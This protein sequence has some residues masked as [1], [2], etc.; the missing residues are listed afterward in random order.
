MAPADKTDERSIV[1]FVLEMRN[2]LERY[3]EEAKENLQQAQA[4]QKKWYDQQARFRKLQPGQKVLLLLLTSTSKLLAKWQGPYTVIRKM[5]PVTYEILHPDKRKSHQTYHVN[6]LKEWKET[7]NETPERSLMVRKVDEPAPDVRPQ[8]HPAKVNLSHLNDPLRAE[9]QDL[10]DRFPLLFRQRSGRTELVQHSIHL[11]D[12]TPSR[13][14]PYRIPERLLKP[15]GEEIEM[16]QLHVIEPSNSEWSSP[17]VIVPKKDGSLRVCVDFRKL[18]AQSR[19][20]AYTMPRIDDL[21]EWIGQARYITTLDLRKGYWQVPLDP[22]S[23]PYTA[24]R[25]PVGLFQFTV[26]PFGLHGAPATFQRLM[27]QVLQG[28]EGWSAAYLDDVVIYSN[29]WAD[30]LEHLRQTLE[31]IQAAGLSLNV[32]KC[33]WARQETGYLGYHLGNGE[34][35]PQVCNMEAIQRSPRPRTKKEVRSFLGLVGWYRR[36]IPDFANIA[37]PL[38]D[39]PTKTGKNPVAWTGACEEAFNT[40]KERMCSSPVLQSPNFDQQFLV[41][42]DA[43][44]KGIGAV[45][46]QGTAGQE[47]PVVFLSRKLLPRETRYSTIEKECLA[48]KWSLESLRYYLLG[49]EFDLE[50]DHRA[51]TWIHTMKYH[52]ARITRWY[53]ALQP[54]S[55]KVRHRPGKLNLVADY[56]SRYL[57]STWL[58]EGEGDVKS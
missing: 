42:V 46:A 16:K 47:K 7:P 17:L 23:K 24:F 38:T 15:L 44:E 8:R 28:C 57:D 35:R 36:F 14:R 45:L 19:F 29:T 40:L 48:I 53:L 3:R 49:R 12:T 51:L 41:Q 37:T 22:N 55:F 34:L 33:E 11:T 56:L 13:Q 2:R 10:L 1:K 25:M 4:S 32:A 6:L 5:G 9:I 30:H 39:L 50:T 20:D 43:S 31:K 18:N 58:G 54:Y 27:D 21:L 26:L 52:N